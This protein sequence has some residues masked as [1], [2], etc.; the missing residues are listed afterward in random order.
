M[1]SSVTVSKTG[2][3]LFRSAVRGFS[4]VELLVVI[5]ILS[6]LMAMALP[7]FVA[8]GPSRK[9]AIHELA[10]FLGNARFRAV[11]SQ[12]EVFV[13][14]A[15]GSFPGEDGQYRS[16][17]IYMEEEAGSSKDEKI[18]RPLRQITPW[19]TLPKGVVFGIGA[20]FEGEDG[21]SL[22]TIFDV[23]SRQEFLV[24]TGT[25]GVFAVRLPYL[26]FAANG[27]ILSPP[28][29][30]SDALHVA[31]VEGG[32]SERG[33]GVSLRGSHAGVNGR[34]E[35]ANGECLRIAYYTGHVRI[36]TD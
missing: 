27:G 20:H 22:R 21:E 10:G 11:S 34:G 5:T 8:L 1:G 17:A 13:A 33:S 19:R 7:G 4:L 12:R 36:I 35:F 6:V 23:P 32:V 18:P 30:E 31:I 2:R 24:K 29:V 14:F 9:T 26:R 28:F 15:D 3:A 25:A 16:Y